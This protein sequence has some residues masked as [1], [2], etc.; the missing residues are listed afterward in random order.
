MEKQRMSRVLPHAGVAGPAIVV[1]WLA[2]GQ[3]SVSPQRVPGPPTFEVATIKP[4]PPDFREMLIDF[5]S[6]GF[7][8]RGFAL[9]DIIAFAY[10][11]DNRQITGL[12]KWSVSE[13][14]DVVGKPE[15]AGLPNSPEI[16]L[17][18]Q[19]LLAER[20]QL[21]IHRDTK[22]IAVYVMTIAKSGVKMSPRTEGDGGAAT[23]WLFQPGK[24]PARNI[25]VQ[26]LAYGL[27]TIVF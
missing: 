10:D 25:S 17:M 1:G 11:V 14:Y 9:R 6:G 24:L 27:Q 4:T 12:P 18:V 19:A 2:F 8:V 7:S 21:K 26:Q 22:N 15:R 3:T 23:R 13:R 5:P 16:K 20:F